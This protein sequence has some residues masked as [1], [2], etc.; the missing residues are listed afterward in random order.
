MKNKVKHVKASEIGVKRK[1]LV[2]VK[3]KRQT[4]DCRL[5]G[6]LAKNKSSMKL[7]LSFTS[8]KMKSAN[9]NS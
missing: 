9:Y 1:V 6:D 8:M 2:K 5:L 7:N 3:L 4:S